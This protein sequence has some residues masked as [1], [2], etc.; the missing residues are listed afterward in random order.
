MRPS[1]R[2]AWATRAAEG[3][4][5]VVIVNGHTVIRVPVTSLFNEGR[6][7]ISPK[8][9]R[10]L[11]GLIAV[12]QTANDNAAVRVVAHTDSRA[13]HTA[14]SS[15]NFELGFAR[16]MLVVHGF[17]QGGVDR[18]FTAGSAAG[19]EPIGDNQTEEGRAANQRIELI[20][21][22]DFTSLPGMEQAV[23][24]DIGPPEAARPG[25]GD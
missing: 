6:V 1:K 9:E 11:Q 2:V 12:F 23:L 24:D 20:I 3:A 10:V 7:D 13:Y 8:G 25:D 14:D 17:E 21:Q 4:L 19:A 5:S 15:S 18:V 22:Q 16:A